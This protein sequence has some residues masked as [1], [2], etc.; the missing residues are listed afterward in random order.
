MV[1]SPNLQ[2]FACNLHIFYI[3]HEKRAPLNNCLEFVDDTVR[4]MPMPDE[5]QRIIYNGNKRVHS[6][7]FQSAITPNGMVAN[8]YDLVEGRRHDS[9]MLGDFCLTNELQQLATGPKK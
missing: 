7:K 3:T 4:T 5:K 1:I 2:F 6:L 8:L 9:G